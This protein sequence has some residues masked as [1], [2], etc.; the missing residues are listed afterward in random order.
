MGGER[1]RVYVGLGSGLQL[2]GERGRLCVGLGSGLKL[3][4]EFALGS[5]M[6][7]ARGR[8]RK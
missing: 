3:A 8:R 1:G 4:L 6:E 5:G 7:S 2:G